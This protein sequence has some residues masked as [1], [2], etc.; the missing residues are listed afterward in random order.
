M[1]DRFWNRSSNVK[2]LEKAR[3]AF[4]Q[5]F[6]YHQS[7]K[8]P[9]SQR[10]TLVPDVR[11][12]ADLLLKSFLE[13][14]SGPLKSAKIELVTDGQLQ[15]GNNNSF[16][17][18][19]ELMQGAKKLPSEKIYVS[20]SNFPMVKFFGRTWTEFEGASG[21]APFVICIQDHFRHLKVS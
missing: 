12:T 16:S 18:S 10:C 15:P 5:P 14:V 19:V 3:R 9:N 17:C 8:K 7:I 13:K 21:I 2:S 1:N 6:C 4:S 11:E 20:F